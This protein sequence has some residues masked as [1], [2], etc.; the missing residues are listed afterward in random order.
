MLLMVRSL[1]DVMLLLQDGQVLD[2]FQMDCQADGSWSSSPPRCRSKK[3]A[4]QT[5]D[6]SA[7]GSLSSVKFH[8]LSRNQIFH[9]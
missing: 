6:E 3:T 5:C 8:F 2:Q 9:I 7:D 1:S 4:V